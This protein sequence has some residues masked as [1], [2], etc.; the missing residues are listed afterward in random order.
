[1][2]NN[3]KIVIYTILVFLI[4]DLIGNSIIG[5]AGQTSL[6]I[7]KSF[8][9]F[10]IYGLIFGLIMVGVNYFLKKMGK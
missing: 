5:W 2:K 9:M 7:L 6:E 4:L 8:G 3:L 1:M 10:A